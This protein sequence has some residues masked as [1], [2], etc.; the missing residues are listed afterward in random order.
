MDDDSA[1]NKERSTGS[2]QDML[3]KLRA[4]SESWY[5][6]AAYL[7]QLTR[8][9]YDSIAIEADTGLEKIQQSVWT[10][11]VEV[12]QSLQRSGECSKETLNYFDREG[13]DVLLYE[14]RFNAGPSRPDAATYI[15]ENQ[16]DTQ[17]ARTLARALKDQ[18]RREGDKLGF[19]AK[20]G[21]CLAFKY[22]RD[23]IEVSRSLTHKE[24]LLKKAYETA[25]TDEARE[26]VKELERNAPA[27]PLKTQRATV[28]VVKL[29]GDQ[30]AF[31]PVPILSALSEASPSSLAAAPVSRSQGAFNS[32]VFGQEAAG[33]PFVM[34]PA[35]HSLMLA[36]RPVG[37]TIPNC[38]DVPAVSGFDANTKPEDKGRM[39]GQ[40]LLI[41]DAA[42]TEA[43]DPTQIYVV[44]VSESALGLSSLA[45]LPEES[46]GSVCGRVLF[47]CRPPARGV[48]TDP[49]VQAGGSNL[50]Q[51]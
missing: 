45:E 41:I 26:A 20:P 31:R 12:Y 24:Q 16:L 7:P 19:S 6:L 46:R 13:A 29:A 47:C 32:F 17:Q 51:L 10:V 21:D 8:A 40:G 18:E 30:T 44:A 22:Y 49:T 11:A 48:D 42:D 50:L 36:R 43:S 4:Q 14:L 23:A 1:Q 37:L 39:E 27:D 35:W 25:V 2:P 34:L 9:G 28:H 33:T 15:A 5:K 3:A 38:A